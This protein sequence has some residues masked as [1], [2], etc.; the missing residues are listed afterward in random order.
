ML[1]IINGIFQS[2]ILLLCIIALITKNIQTNL[3]FTILLCISF[4]LGI[5]SL[6]MWFI[7]KHKNYETL[8]K[9]KD[10]FTK[11]TKNLLR[12]QRHDYMNTFQIIYGYLQLNN[13]EKA[14]KH[15]KKAITISSSAGRCYYLSVFSVSLLLEK[16]IKQG[17]NKGIEVI[18]DIDSYVD[19]EI[20]DIKNEKIILYHISEILDI[21]INCT[22]KDNSEAK[23]LID[24][25]EHIDRIE[26]V[27][28]GDIDTNLLETKCKEK[29][30]VT[31]TNDD[32]EVIFYFDKTKDLLLDGNVCF[33]S[34]SY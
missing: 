6:L 29:K 10:S 30:N 33:I 34:N 15:I 18:I 21:F 31:K 9:T 12:E 5:I 23:L 26:F 11:D 2:A 25:Y 3:F 14:M 32:Y 22:Y 17:E 13:R 27:F 24:I 7:F 4:L 8:R 1:A 19:N 20:R 16:K 28:S